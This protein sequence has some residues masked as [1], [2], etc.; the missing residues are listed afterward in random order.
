MAKWVFENG[1][2]GQKYASQ[3][4]LKSLILRIQNTPPESF[5]PPFC[6]KVAQTE[7]HPSSFLPCQSNVFLCHVRGATTEKTRE[8]SVTVHSE[9]K[10][11][12]YGLCDCG[13][14]NINTLAFQIE[15]TC[16]ATEISIG[17][18]QK[19]ADCNENLFLRY[20]ISTNRSQYIKVQKLFKG[21][22]Y[23]RAET[24]HG[25]MVGHQGLA[26]FCRQIDS[27][28][29]LIYHLALSMRQPSYRTR[30]ILNP[31]FV[32]FLPHLSVQE[33]LIL[34]TV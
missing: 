28:F 23:S 6:S 30:A 7:H 18:K 26:F 29:S 22:N 27:E 9:L 19:V 20:R 2:D 24:I 21:G 31:R 17:N 32:C 5:Y 1:S 25:N 13:H 34:Q 11:V 3:I 33:R 14:T 15:T 16:Q 12:L 10:L 4:S 8:T